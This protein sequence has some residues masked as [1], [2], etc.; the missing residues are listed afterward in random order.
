MSRCLTSFVQIFTSG[1]HL[2]SFIMA[3]PRLIL[4]DQCVD[5]ILF[6]S[7]A[8]TKTN[9]KRLDALNLK[10]SLTKEEEREVE[11]LK[12]MLNVTRPDLSADNAVVQQYQ[13]YWVELLNKAVLKKANNYTFITMND[14]TRNM[15][16]KRFQTKSDT[17]KPI[18]LWLE[19]VDDDNNHECTAI[20]LQSNT[21]GI[22]Y[23]PN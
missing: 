8:K 18:L 9:L 4:A 7:S 16:S 11:M 22:Q 1:L 2:L 5:W 6:T 17:D 15:F 14:E 20:M 3:D 12:P 23:V 10:P 13:D 21:I 19:Y